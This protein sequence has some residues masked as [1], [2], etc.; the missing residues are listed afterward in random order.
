MLCNFLHFSHCNSTFCFISINYN[1]VT[2]P[3]L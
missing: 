3:Y 1:A 2:G